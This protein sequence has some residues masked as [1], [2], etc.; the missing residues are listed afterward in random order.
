MIAVGLLQ[1]AGSKPNVHQV[2][3]LSNCPLLTFVMAS[4]ALDAVTVRVAPVGL[5]RTVQVLVEVGGSAELPDPV[6]ASNIPSSA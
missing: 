2:A 3:L 1:S 4:S 5:W 6:A